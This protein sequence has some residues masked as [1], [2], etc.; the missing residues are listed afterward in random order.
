MKI[1]M[2]TKSSQLRVRKA[3]SLIAAA[4]GCLLILAFAVPAN[5][6]TFQSANTVTT[7]WAGVA[8]VTVSGPGGVT[9]PTSGVIVHGTA[10]SQFLNGPKGA[11][12]LFACQEPGATQPCKTV[13]HLWYGDAINGLCRVDP[14]L[15]ANLATPVNGFGAWNVNALACVISINK[16]ALAPGQITLD[17]KNNLM[18]LTNNS[19][20]GAGIARVIFHP[21]G[22]N[23]QGMVDLVNIVSMIGTQTNRNAFGGC[24]QMTDP[25]NGALVP[26]IPDAAA[27]GPDGNLYTGQIR[28]GAI[29]RFINAAN[30]NPATDCPGAGSS[31]QDPNA[32]IQIPIL[33]HDELFGAG[34]TF[35][36]GW[37][38]DTLF[39][40]DNIAP[41]V[42][43]HATQCLTPANGNT[44]CAN[45][46]VG[47]SPIPNEIL[48][49]AAGAPQGGLASDA[50]YPFF[51]GNSV[52]V[53]SFPNLTRVTNILSATQ[54]TANLQYG[55]SFSFL[56]GVTADPE[57]PGNAIVYAED[58][59]TQGG[60]NGTGRIWRI[61][62]APQAPGP[63]AAPAISG[64]TAGPGSGQ[65]TLSWTPIVNGQ[66][67]STYDIQILL[68]SPTGGAPTPS[69]LPDTIVNAPATSAVISGLTVGTGYQFNIQACNANGC[70]VFAGPSPIVTPFATTAPGA[71]TNVV[72]V[73]SGDGSS[74]AVAWTQ[75]DN[76]HSAVTSSAISVFTGSPATLVK[77]V[78]ILGANTGGTVTGLTC[79]PTA[80]YQ[81]SV[82]ATNAIGTSP[83]SALSASVPLPCVTAADVSATETSPANVN[84]GSQV[85]YTISIHNNGP[86]PA[87]SVGFLDTLPAGLVSFTTSQGVCTGTQTL[88]TFN[89]AL[90]TIP[91]AG[92]ATVTVTVLLPANTTGSFTNSATVT[93]TDGTQAATNVDPNLTN[94]TFS[95]TTTVGASCS[96]TT[97]DLQVTGA[98]NNGNPV[99]GSPVTFTWQI[100]DG[101]GTIPANCSLFTATTTA[102]AG[103]SLTISGASTTLGSCAIANNQVSCNFGNIPGAGAVTVTITAS[104]SAAA[105][106][107]SYTM[108]GSASFT[109]T[110]TN[111]ANN[112]ATVAIGAQ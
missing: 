27:V 15:D 18:Y 38:G 86:A 23:G 95:S 109:G 13:R 88:T 8:D 61:T 78:T 34:H 48:A 25:H 98:S 89:C 112:T 45:P 106:A 40:A 99:H 102:P 31:G 49:S 58:D 66:P 100:K 76:G 73:S 53:A 111:Q 16:L 91:V 24:P 4:L 60:I 41:W 2:T 57:D 75:A 28:D 51:P 69:G 17:A 110:D 65:A 63:P 62:P 44:A 67:T 54:M 92:N 68:A 85:T 104:A 64:V 10:P 103:Q 3:T 82:T 107:N 80:S 5:A 21:D 20:V 43:F 39:G 35:G 37:V 87:P 93:A 22:D 97:T 36:L 83:A 52:Y 84:A 6:Q 29:L 19:R 70:S 26:Q 101:Q 30:F 96:A 12:G 79:G 32:K 7:L 14:E 108:T 72:A 71:P 94:N 50:Q 1:P 9:L 46:L 59:A 55:G 47:G 90:G 77:T 56:T 74:I 11:D 81:F 105:P 33:A 42:E